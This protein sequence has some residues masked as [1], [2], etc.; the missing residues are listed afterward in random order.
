[1]F[2]IEVNMQYYYT[3]IPNFA[4]QIDEDKNFTFEL[5]LN[6]EIYMM[7]NTHIEHLEKN[8]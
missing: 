3:H 8:C 5:L 1:M 7:Q 4:F 6:Q 2:W